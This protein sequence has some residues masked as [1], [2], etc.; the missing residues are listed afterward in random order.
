MRNLKE[1]NAD[2][3][4][5][6]K[7]IIELEKEK[8]NIKFAKEKHNKKFA[9]EREV[10]YSLFKDSDENLLKASEVLTILE[11]NNYSLFNKFFLGKLLKKIGVKYIIDRHLH[12]NLYFLEEL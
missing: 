12:I 3:R 8:Y 9:D 11:K 4:K 7:K 6:S 10:I 5:Y 2:I 1:I